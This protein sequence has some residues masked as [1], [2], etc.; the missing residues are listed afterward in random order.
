MRFSLPIKVLPNSS[1]WET[2]LLQG[3]RKRESE[4]GRAG[5]PNSFL[6]TRERL[7]ESNGPPE[8]LGKQHPSSECAAYWAE[9]K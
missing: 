4:V 7:L 3:I 9:H 6:D 8:A 2:A 5:F 1:P